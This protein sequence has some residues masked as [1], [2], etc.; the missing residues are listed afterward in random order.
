MTC[1][2]CDRVH[3]L[4]QPCL[5]GVLLACGGRAYADEVF[6]YATLDRTARR[7]VIEMVRHGACPYGGADLLADRWARSR[8]Y[9]VDPMPADFARLGRA[10]GPIRND[11]M[12]VKVPRPVA[13]VA[14]P[15]DRGTRDMVAKCKA[16][17][18]RVPVWTAGWDG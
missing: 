11:Q 14:F 5:R 12:L 15:G 10:A 4:D 17:T 9:A 6:V 16:V 7:M 18:P 13:C 8:G 1:T 2:A 3:R